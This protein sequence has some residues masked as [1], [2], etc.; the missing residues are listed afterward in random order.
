MTLRGG[1][2]GYCAAMTFNDNARVETSRV[3]RG[4]RGGGVVAVGGGAALVLFLISQLIGVDLTG[5]A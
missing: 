1:G 4:G 2:A 5:L 3:R